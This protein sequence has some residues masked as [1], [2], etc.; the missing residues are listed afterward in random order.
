MLSVTELVSECSS[1]VT[2]PSYWQSLVSRVFIIDADRTEATV[3]RD[4]RRFPERCV[5]GLHNSYHLPCS[6]SGIRAFPP[7]HVPPWASMPHRSK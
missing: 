1:S 6:T 5:G 3:T 7:V 4:L 2:W